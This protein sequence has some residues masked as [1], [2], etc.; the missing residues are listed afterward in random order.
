MANGGEDEDGVEATTLQRTLGKER[1]LIFPG[2]FAWK[3]HGQGGLQNACPGIC[4]RR[5][6]V[7]LKVINWTA[8][9]L[10]LSI[11]GGVRS[12]IGT[13]F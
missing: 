1:T 5:F 12:G 6:Y 4:G 11:E 13:A 9:V 8:K 10:D 2:V 3:P 7:C